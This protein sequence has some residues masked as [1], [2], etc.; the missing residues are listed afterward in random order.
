MT[1]ETPAIT[2]RRMAFP[3]PTLPVREWFDSNPWLASYFCAL[4]ATFPDGER[5][6]IDS[7][8]HYR[9]R[10]KDP[11][12]RSRVSA[13]IGQEAHHGKAHEAL[14]EALQ[15]Q[16]VPIEKVAGWSLSNLNFVRRK[17]SPGRQLAITAALEHVTAT[18]ADHLLS[19]PEKLDGL[20]SGFRDMLVWHAVE[21][22]EHKSVAFD[23][24]REQVNNEGLRRQV[25]GITLA[26]FSSR[27]FFYQCYIML[28][29][30][31][32]PG[33]VSTWRALVFFWGKQGAMRHAVPHLA[34]A[35]RHGFHPEDIDQT[36][37]IDGWEQRFPVV[38]GARQA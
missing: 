16:G 14:N 25:M 23:V 11:E 17:L 35:F 8:R 29:M 32:L 20:D 22:I 1:A 13:F 5:F 21:E 6:F 24:F 31:C 26:M 12:L 7:V 18:L 15:A 4:S 33:P 37:L 28:K 27:I 2:I 9:D 30:R 38:A 34:A 19:N 36:A 10:I 3:A